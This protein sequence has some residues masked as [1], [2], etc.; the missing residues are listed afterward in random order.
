MARSWR[1]ISASP[2]A[3]A[4]VIEEP[5]STTAR[6]QQVERPRSSLRLVNPEFGY[7]K[8][9]L[10]PPTTC[11]YLYIAAAVHPGPT[12]VVL[13]RRQR[14]ALL[15]LLKEAASQLSSV[16][17]V[18]AVD[19]FRAIVMPPTARFSAYLKARRGAPRAANFDV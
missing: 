4:A 5:M 15:A 7:P 3:P 11:G 14:T 10:V 13:P 6:A 9:R 18:V 12:P 1:S 17:D 2:P 19:V 16:D 8:A